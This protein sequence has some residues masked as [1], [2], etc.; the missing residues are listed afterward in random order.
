MGDLEEELLGVG[1]VSLIRRCVSWWKGKGGGRAGGKGE[2]VVRRVARRRRWAKSVLTSRLVFCASSP[3][4]RSSKSTDKGKDRMNEQ[5][6]VSLTLLLLS[7]FLPPN[8][9]PFPCHSADAADSSFSVLY[10]PYLRSSSNH[11]TR[12]IP[13]ATPTFLPEPHLSTT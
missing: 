8:L 3:E 7:R 10:P 5:G 9:S 6:S 12:R 1:K 4:Q 13:R 2:R 11:S